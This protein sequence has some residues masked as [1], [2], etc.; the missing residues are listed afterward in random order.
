M[1]ELLRLEAAAGFDAARRL[2]N[3][4]AADPRARWHGHSF[5]VAARAQARDLEALQRALAA[6]VAPLD[7][8]AL[9]VPLAEPSDEQLAAWIA[10]RIDHPGLDQLVLHAGAQRGALWTPGITRH[11][12]RYSFQAAHRLPHVPLM[13]KCGRMHGHGFGVLLL[14]DASHDRID[15]AWAPLHVAL[16]HR[17]LNDIEGLH[18]PTSEMLAAWL[19]QQLQPGLPGLHRVTVF[20]TGSSGA[21]YDGARFRIWKQFTLDSAVR[22][23]RGLYGHTF[24]LWLH[25]S[26][27]LDELL[28]WVVDFGDVKTLFAPIFEQLDHQ[29]LHELAGVAACDCASLARW[30]YE[31]ASLQLPQLDRIDL[32]QTPG[33]GAVL[34]RDAD[35]LVPMI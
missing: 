31:R 15:E 18:N 6:A 12:R 27:P 16:Q 2:T 4:P 33:C 30:V 26:A 7:H 21:A 32:H 3:V 28:G 8:Q 14:A 10:E 23:E 1:S 24:A 13:H 9:Q 17:C 29:P 11:W 19:W 34:A 5:H 25:L 35:A 20:E 22:D